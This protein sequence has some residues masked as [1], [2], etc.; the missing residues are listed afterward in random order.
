MSRSIILPILGLAAIILYGTTQAALPT[1]EDVSQMQEA[2]RPAR[3]APP[4]RGAPPPAPP[5][6][7]RL[8]SEIEAEEAALARADSARR[9]RPADTTM[10]PPPTAGTLDGPTPDA[11]VP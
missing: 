8:R 1:A 2:A 10:T 11:P 4:P 5:P 6:A 7:P 3:Q 9:A